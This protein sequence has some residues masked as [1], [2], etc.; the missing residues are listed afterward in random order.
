M[1]FRRPSGAQPA[2]SYFQT[3]AG[4]R[5]RRQG[6]V[7]LAAFLLGYLA[8]MFTLFPAPLLSREH[9][10]PSVMDVGVTEAR[11]TLE[12]Q[13][14]RPRIEDQQTDP[15]APRGA[16]IWQDPPPGVVLPPNAPVSLTL[17]E[18]PP[19]VPVPD[20]AGFPRAL[21]ERVLKAA[22]FGLGTL[23]TLP[24]AGEAGMVVQSR[25]GA[26]VGRPARTPV[27]LVISSG[28]AELTVPGVVG[29]SLADAR[30][31]I[32][33]AGLV[34]GR[35]GYRITPGQAEGVV[36]DQRPPGGTRSPRGG[37]ME[38]IVTRKGP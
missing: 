26:G 20:V 21:A 4:Q 18:G 35:V 34:V 10:V 38:L 31:R 13:G 5:L 28:P 12:K 27:D 8:T 15:S 9:A 17:S 30:D 29:L 11:A 1:Q 36:L 2:K 22:G 32:T 37:A 25:P 24:A 7:V 6:L 14:F 33:G 16:V 23:D 19:D 3:I